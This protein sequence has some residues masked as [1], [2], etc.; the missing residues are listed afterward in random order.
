VILS[1][2][3]DLEMQAIELDIDKT[4]N[5]ES[6]LVDRIADNIRNVMT[7]KI[8]SMYLGEKN[9]LDWIEREHPRVPV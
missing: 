2:S 4:E 7:L 3:V 1:T 9:R 5:S 8:Q 6:S